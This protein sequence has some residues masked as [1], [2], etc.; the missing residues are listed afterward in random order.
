MP[1]TK[2]CCYTAQML[3]KLQVNW[4]ATCV[5][6]HLLLKVSILWPT[7]A[8]QQVYLSTSNCTKIQFELNFFL[9]PSYNYCISLN[10]IF[11]WI[12]SSGLVILLLSSA[13]MKFN[14]NQR[15]SAISS[16][17]WLAKT[18]GSTCSPRFLWPWVSMLKA[19]L[20]HCACACCPMPTA[21]QYDSWIMQPS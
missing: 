19:S 10:G 2:P 16:K 4:S 14:R 5:R 1:P 6:G 9:F 20:L 7:Q 12:L 18:V 3:W 17:L 15:P 11:S 8:A 13:T 21:Q